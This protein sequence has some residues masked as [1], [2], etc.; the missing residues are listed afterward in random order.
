MI[1]HED[2]DIKALFL[3]RDGVVNIEKQYVYRKED[4]EFVDGIFDLC[5]R[6]IAAGYRVIVI[7][8]QSGIARGFYSEQAF[9]ELTAWMKTEFAR[10]GIEIAAVYYCPYHPDEGIGKYHAESFDRKPNPGMILRAAR[11]FELDLG[12]CILVGDRARDLQ[13]AAAAGVG[14]KILYRTEHSEPEAIRGADRVV[15]RL[16]EILKTG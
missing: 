14:C 6:A 2:N 10:R 4:V 1:P 11:D 15:D 13:A 12:Q 5:R 8:N 9:H 3:D 7:T 16:D